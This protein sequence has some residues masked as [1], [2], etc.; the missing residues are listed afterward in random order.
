MFRT[1]FIALMLIIGMSFGASAMADESSSVFNSSSCSNLKNTFMDVATNKT[2]ENLQFSYKEAFKCNIEIL[3]KSIIVK[4][5]YMVFGEFALDAMDISISIIQPLF[6]LNIDFKN[7]ALSNMN[8]ISVIE[9]FTTMITSV[10]YVIGLLL[11]II[12]GVSY[13]MYA[14][15]SAQDGEVLGKGYNT[16]WTVVRGAFVIMLLMPLESLNNYSAVQAISIM[17]AVVGTVLANLI[18]F[19]MPVFEYLHTFNTEDIKN[20]NEY[21]QKTAVS[22]FVNLNVKMHMCDIQA[23]KQIYTNGKRLDGLT[24][25]NIEGSN[26]G[27]CVNQSSVAEV[28]NLNADSKKIIPSELSLTKSCASNPANELKYNIDCGYITLKQKDGGLEAN[29]IAETYQSEIRE[30]A[31][32]LIG[33]YCLDNQGDRAEGDKFNYLKECADINNGSSLKYEN[34]TGKNILTGYKNAASEKEII[35]KINGIKDSLYND[36]T[37]AGNSIISTSITDEEV[38]QKIASSLIRGWLAASSFII[39]IGSSLK[40]RDIMFN[41]AFEQLGVKDNVYINGS[42]STILGTNPM[43]TEFKRN[44]SNLNAYSDN[45][46]ALVNYLSTTNV[47]SESQSNEQYSNGKSW[48]SVA[49]YDTSS[50]GNF[51]STAFFPGL[52]YVKKFSIESAGTGSGGTQNNSCLQDFTNCPTSSLNVI[53]DLIKLGNQ[54]LSNATYGFIVSKVLSI[55]L[56]EKT[57]K[58]IIDEEQNAG[59]LKPGINTAVNALNFFSSMFFLYIILGALIC[60]LPAIVIFVFFVGNA[61]GWFMMVINFVVTS[62]LWLIMHIIPGK[63]IQGFAGKGK[64][65]YTMLL[66]IMIRPSFIVFGAFA[67]FIIMSAMVSLYSVMFGMV[68]STF[69]F[70]RTPG[71]LFE[72]VSNYIIHMI[73]LVMLL[74]IIYRSCKSIY[75]IPNALQN[76]L[77]IKVYGDASAWNQIMQQFKQLTVANTRNIINVNSLFKS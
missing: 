25:S 62:Q 10:T 19:L 20:A 14:V 41:A 31:Y 64:K 34:S 42:N 11:A 53:T 72:F 55:A 5:M 77:N 69:A 15:S 37:K 58:I 4:L 27:Q 45:V 76:W 36:L 43:T 38:S 28:S 8:N 71:T 44:M 13:I 65:G 7:D 12:V 23:R 63:N 40:D 68:L 22:D 30:V 16:L 1:L 24:Q 33:R 32:D 47:S 70:F 2:T 9:M 61:I 46:I 75:K 74:V 3:P 52:Q 54:M 67:T 50:V 73:Y 49:G 60:Y 48:Y 39:E 56:T 29:S 17:A 18:W 57:E 66:D 26:F 51:I 35:I 59:I 21:P 6:G